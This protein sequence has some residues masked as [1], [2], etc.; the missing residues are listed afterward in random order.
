MP[1]AARSTERATTS[2][3]RLE[4]SPGRGH[5]T[6]S[7]R[8]LLNKCP[9]F[10]H[11]GGLTFRG[12]RLSAENCPARRVS[13]FRT[14]VAAARRHNA[15][16][17]GLGGKF[18]GKPKRVVDGQAGPHPLHGVA[19]IRA[20]RATVRSVGLVPFHRLQKAAPRRRSL[21]RAG[22][23]RAA[24]RY[25]QAM[26]GAERAAATLAF[27]HCKPSATQQSQEPARSAALRGP[28]PGGPAEEAQ[29]GSADCGIAVVRRATPHEMRELSGA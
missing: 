20:L 11:R 29:Q 1:A 3:N 25:V 6:V 15:M 9:D 13:S 2:S 22:R 16:V 7:N 10:S 4:R 12:A 23:G 24:V 19:R 5:T 21:V 27:Q 8:S 28:A 26:A 17:Q 14:F 18:H